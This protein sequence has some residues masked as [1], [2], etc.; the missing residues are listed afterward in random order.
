[1][2]R[3]YKERHV[4]YFKCEKCGTQNRQSLKRARAKNG[5]CRSCKFKQVN[6]NQIP[7]FTPP[8]E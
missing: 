3:Q 8:T 6:P 1:M 7:L 2:K 5:V 4:Y